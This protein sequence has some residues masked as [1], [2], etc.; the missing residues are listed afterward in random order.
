MINTARQI[1]DIIDDYINFK[2]IKGAGRRCGAQGFAKRFASDTLG[3]KENVD[4]LMEWARENIP[5]AEKSVL[6]DQLG[7]AGWKTALLGLQSRMQ[8]EG[9][10]EEAAPDNTLPAPGVTAANVGSGVP[11]PPS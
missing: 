9:G 4:N 8:L 1:L 3:G 5:E 7:G 11:E 6:N 10:T 2:G